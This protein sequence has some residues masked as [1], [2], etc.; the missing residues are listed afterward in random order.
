MPKTSFIIIVS[1][2]TTLS[3]AQVSVHPQDVL[4]NP[5]QG[6][7]RLAFVSWTFDQL[8]TCPPSLLIMLLVAKQIYLPSQK[9][10][11]VKMTMLSGQKL[12]PPALSLSI[13]RVHDRRRGGA[14]LL[15]RKIW[16]FK[17]LHRRNIVHLVIWSSLSHLAPLKF[18]LSSFTA[19]PIR[20][21]NLSPQALFPLTLRNIWKPYFSH[22]N[23]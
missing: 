23:R 17:T 2:D 13:S 11:W 1:L 5:L 8:R 15:F 16:M 3:T 19:H 22:L 18:A 9:H 4:R 6:N 20:L 21:H 14:A 7:L 10:G 12:H